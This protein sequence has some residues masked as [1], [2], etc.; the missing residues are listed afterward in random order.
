MGQGPLNGLRIIEFVGIGPGPYA[1]MLLTD[2]GAEVLSI[3]R[4]GA[5]KAQYQTLPHGDANQL[6]LM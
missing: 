1:S 4:K 3:H 2:M 6:R 5:E